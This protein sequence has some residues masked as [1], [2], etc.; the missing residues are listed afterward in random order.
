MSTTISPPVRGKGWIFQVTALCIVLGMLLALALKTQRQAVS[1]GIPSR[2]PALRT[3]FRN[4]KL[5]NNKL[6]KDLAEYK[7]R[8]EELLRKQARGIRGAES[9]EAMLAQTKLFAGLTAVRGPGVVVTLNDSPKR[10]P[11]ETRQEVI[12]NYLVHDSDIRAVVNELFASGAEAI[13]INGQRLIASSSIRCVGP[14][15]LVNSVQVAVP[16]VIKAIGNPENLEKALEMPGGPADGLFLLDMIEIKKQPDMIV[17]AYTG[18]T[19]F[20][21]ARPLEEQRKEE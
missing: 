11:S 20:T 5:E 19:R 3:E 21:Y 12:S 14:V 16:Y 17:P 15:V 13:S 10:N 7:T 2:W 1:E 9:L 6:Q 18:S 4:L 8:Y